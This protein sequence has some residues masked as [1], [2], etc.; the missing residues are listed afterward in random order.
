MKKTTTY[1]KPKVYL[2]GDDV[3]VVCKQGACNG[4]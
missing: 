3:F 1:E 2:I 4:K